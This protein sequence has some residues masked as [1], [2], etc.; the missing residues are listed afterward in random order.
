MPLRIRRR[1][2]RY[3]PYCRYWGWGWHHPYALPVPPW[4]E[5]LT[6]KE[7]KEYLKEHIKILEEELKAAE[8]E[9]KELEKAK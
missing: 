1:L 2:R 5:E 7:E 4:I 3:W 9:L 8:E 6:P